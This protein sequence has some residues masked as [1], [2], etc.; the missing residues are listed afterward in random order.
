M[1]CPS[2]K[3]RWA[4]RGGAHRQAKML[5]RSNRHASRSERSHIEVREYRCEVCGGWHVFSLNERPGVVFE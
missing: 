2:G 5:T 1:K 3:Q 4:K